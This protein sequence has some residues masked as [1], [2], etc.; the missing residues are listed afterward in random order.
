MVG[1][2]LC[3]LMLCQDVVTPGEFFMTSL[4]VMDLYHFLFGST[5]SC[6]IIAITPCLGI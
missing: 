6:N 2:C 1:L 4:G 3:L 5:N